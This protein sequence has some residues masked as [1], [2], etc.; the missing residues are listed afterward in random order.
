MCTYVHTTNSYIRLLLFVGRY[1]H[2]PD[3]DIK[4]LIMCVTRYHVTYCVDMSRIRI[5]ITGYVLCWSVCPY[6]G[7]IYTVNYGGC[8]YVDAP[9]PYIKVTYGV[10]R[11][12]QT[13]DPYIRLLSV[14]VAIY[15]ITHCVYLGPE[16]GYTDPQNK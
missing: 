2:I 10:S 6:S 15:N 12:V 5:Q 8:R 3:P 1:V 9:D 7:S 16:P 14:R 11:Y 4:L 13:P